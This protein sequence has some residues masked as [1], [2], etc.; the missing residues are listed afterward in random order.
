MKRQSKSSQ[1][2][3]QP[4]QVII[5]NRPFVSPQKQCDQCVE[6]SGM[7][8]P[9]EAAALSNVSTRTIYHWLESNSIHF[10]ETPATGLLICLQTLGKNISAPIRHSPANSRI[11]R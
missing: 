8:T 5:I 11:K 7:I 3:A 10:F 9:D 2:A 6:P 4:R 1:R